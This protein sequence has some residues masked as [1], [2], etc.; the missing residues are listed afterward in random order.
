MVIPQVIIQH[1]YFLQNRRIYP[2]NNKN[3]FCRLYRTDGRTSTQHHHGLRPRYGDGHGQTGRVRPPLQ[4][5]QQ[6]RRLLHEDGER[7]Q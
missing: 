5:A 7:N 4:T 3:S 6:P 1:L 2:K